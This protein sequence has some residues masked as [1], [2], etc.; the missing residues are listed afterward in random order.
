[1]SNELN[2]AERVALEVIWHRQGGFKWEKGLYEEA[3]RAVV[4]AVRPIIEAGILREFAE[5]LDK[6]PAAYGTDPEYRSGIADAVGIA[7]ARADR[8]DNP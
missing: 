1:M 8:R 3:A 7:R 4:A 2:E 5:T 6:L